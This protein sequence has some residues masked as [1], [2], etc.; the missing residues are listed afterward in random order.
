MALKAPV[1]RRPRV[2]LK[3]P[4]APF[5]LRVSMPSVEPLLVPLALKVL[6]VPTVLSLVILP[7]TLASYVALV[8]TQLERVILTASLA[9]R[10][11]IAQTVLEDRTVAP[12]AALAS[13]E[14]TVLP[15][16]P[17]PRTLA[18]VVWRAHGALQVSRIAYLVWQVSKALTDRLPPLVV[19]LLHA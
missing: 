15:F 18:L 2:L 14:P 6:R 13:K 3:P 19:V 12:R 1:L 8:F 16:A 11:L 4:L 9:A 17:L 5:V 7:P 10:A